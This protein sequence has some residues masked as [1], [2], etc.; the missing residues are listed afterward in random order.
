MDEPIAEKK[1]RGRKPKEK[2]PTE[3][4]VYKKRGRRPK[5]KNEE[6]TNQ[7]ND[8]KYSLFKDDNN[9]LALILESCIIHLRLLGY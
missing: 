6:E 1:K 5:I 9:E 2:P 7:Q 3:E 4:K 8:K